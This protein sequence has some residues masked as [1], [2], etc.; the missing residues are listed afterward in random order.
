MRGEGLFAGAVLGIIFLMIIPLSPFML[1]LLLSLSI[2]LSVVTLLLTLYIQETLDFSTFPT[3]LLFLSCFRLGLNFAST[4]L[5]LTTQETGK[6]IQTFGEFVCT[7]N[8]LVGFLLFIILT[9]VNFMVI[10]KGAGR[11]AEVS[12]RF[13]LEALPGKQL[14]IENE[15]QGQLLSKEEARIAYQKVGA[16][17]EFFGSMDGAAKFLRGEAVAALLITGVNIVGGMGVGLFYNSYSLLDSFKLFT[18]LTIG[19]GL[20]TQLPALLV[21]LGAGILIT[22][23]SRSSLSQALPQQLFSNPKVL[24][25]G[26]FCLLL[27]AL[28]PGMP[29]GILLLV[30]GAVFVLGRFTKKQLEKKHDSYFT[31]LLEL[32]ISSSYPKKQLEN[33]LPLL[34]KKWEQE[35]GIAL[36]IIHLQEDNSLADNFYEFK[37]KGVTV[38]RGEAEKRELLLEKLHNK[39]SQ[40]GHEL[41]NRQDI[42]NLL[43]RARGVDKAVVEELAS[44]KFLLSDLLK[45]IQNL[46]REQVAVR[47][48][49]SLL[50]MVADHLAKGSLD[51][52]SLDVDLLTEQVRLRFAPIIIEHFFGSQTTLHAITLDAE[53]EEI[54]SSSFQTGGAKARFLLPPKIMENIEKSIASLLQQAKEQKIAL[55]ILTGAKSRVSISRFLERFPTPPPTLSYAEIGHRKVEILGQITSDALAIN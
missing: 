17:A 26:A 20:V 23:S 36:P 8:H 37:I 55:L 43:E 44:R 31:P 15:V 45:L 47:D 49:I 28:I 35:W 5:I 53:V 40:H 7:G 18:L 54:I 42:A 9:I 46:L 32:R 14:A 6:I 11:I 41:I 3:L 52:G 22:R 29:S 1:D 24:N 19:D 34:Q 21:S 48:F 12:A 10:T 2:L 30:G 38:Q 25:V 16:E 39:V 51:K 33:D 13:T 27:L 4:R 50:E